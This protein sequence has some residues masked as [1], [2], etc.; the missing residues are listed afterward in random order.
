MPRKIR[1]SKGEVLE[2][3]D[4]FELPSPPVDNSAAAISAA[5]NPDIDAR[6]TN[7]IEKMKIDPNS[8]RIGDITGQSSGETAVDVGQMVGGMFG[9]VLPI[10][11]IVKQFITNPIATYLGGKIG[12]IIGEKTGIAENIPEDQ[13]TQAILSSYLGSAVKGGTRVAQE[14]KALFDAINSKNVVSGSS[15]VDWIK[16]RYK[17]SPFNF[18][19]DLPMS[20]DE[21]G[22]ITGESPFLREQEVLKFLR[23]NK[24][25]IT[26]SQAT[27]SGTA[28]R[29]EATS[30]RLNDIFNS[31]DVAMRNI[32]SDISESGLKNTP[33]TR[34]LSWEQ[35]IKDALS[36]MIQ[37]GRV[38]EVADFKATKLGRT[39]GTPTG[40]GKKNVKLKS[41][42]EGLREVLREDNSADFDRLTN[43]LGKKRTAEL[44][45]E[46]FISEAFDQGGR[47]STTKAR[48][49]LMAQKSKF[50][51]TLSSEERHSINRFMA[52]LDINDRRAEAAR[53]IPAMSR[54]AEN[55]MIAA[56]PSIGMTPPGKMSAMTGR[57]LGRA[58]YFN[59]E[60]HILSKLVTN[61]Q[62]SYAA[63]RLMELPAGSTAAKGPLKTILGQIGKLGLTVKFRMGDAE[64]DLKPN[65]N[66][67]FQ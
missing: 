37:E 17:S 18:E 8:V 28:A 44:M 27:R 48:S 10:N 31:Q 20:T 24:Y 11:G 55:N 39:L 21:M 36:R 1:N 6:L 47:F 65:E 66:G 22:N 23:K 49:F 58:G 43:I 50:L 51:K 42:E 34:A 41:A 13:A 40:T 61:P 62:F 35:E 12:G 67:E 45:K 64:L 26:T 14:G 2:I 4:D 16:N 52:A 33:Q 29:Q 19:P 38:K 56:I 25:P 3:P 9:E 30:P 54:G 7:L 5:K 57:I 46:A 32:A 53:Y 60:K 63:A 15:L 59:I